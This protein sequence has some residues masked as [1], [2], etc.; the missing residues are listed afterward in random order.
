MLERHRDRRDDTPS[1]VGAEWPRA[2]RSLS[3]AV[4]ITAS[5]LAAAT[6]SACGPN[7]DGRGAAIFL[8]TL[9]SAFAAQSGNYDALA[10]TT[11]MT[12]ALNYGVGEVVTGPPAMAPNYY[13]TYGSPQT[14]ADYYAQSAYD[15]LQKGTHGLIHGFEDNSAEPSSNISEFVP[16]QMRSLPPSGT[17]QKSNELSA[18]GNLDVGIEHSRR[19]IKNKAE[20]IANYNLQGASPCRHRLAQWN[21]DQD[22]IV[23]NQLD[24]DF[25]ALNK[26]NVLQAKKFVDLM[27]E[28]KELD[29]TGAY[30]NVMEKLLQNGQAT[31]RGYCSNSVGMP[32]S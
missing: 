10:A 29:T 25:C 6:T 5:I 27:R 2:R 32:T 26:A 11:G 30:R 12:K 7:G 19:R 1:E 3:V 28:C 8:T 31:E 24:L 17:N 20:G 15:Y 4:G 18:F 13:G 23:V 22:E 9:G 16:S 14:K 21:D